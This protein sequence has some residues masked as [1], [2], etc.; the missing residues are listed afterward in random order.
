MGFVGG[1]PI[2]RVGFIRGKSHIQGFATP[3]AAR[4][5]LMPAGAKG[6]FK[7]KGEKRG[8]R[9]EIKKKKRDEKGKKHMFI[10]LDLLSELS[11]DWVAMGAHPGV[12]LEGA[13]LRSPL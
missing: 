1:N 11:G 3:D 13:A 6:F 4:S 8:E 7:K 12:R 9:Q 2:S 10:L 5:A